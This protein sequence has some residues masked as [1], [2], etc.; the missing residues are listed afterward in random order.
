MNVEEAITVLG[1]GNPELEKAMR[2]VMAKHQSSHVNYQQEGT[3]NTYQY[4]GQQDP[5][6]FNGGYSHFNQYPQSQ[7]QYYQSQGQQQT[8]GDANLVLPVSIGQ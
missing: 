6:F 3:Q 5:S 8:F 7:Y 2:E 1:Q 4:S